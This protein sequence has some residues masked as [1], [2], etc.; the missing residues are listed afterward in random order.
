MCRDLNKIIDIYIYILSVWLEVREKEEGVV[1][2]YLPIE[3]LKNQQ[4]ALGWSRYWDANPVPIKPLA[5]DL[6]TAPSWPVFS[7]VIFIII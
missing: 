5:D 7:N 3:H 2:L 1:A 6:T 4:P